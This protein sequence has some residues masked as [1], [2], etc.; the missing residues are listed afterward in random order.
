[1]VVLLNHINHLKENSNRYTI[2]A[3]WFH[4][5]W[6]H[7]VN[8]WHVVS[9]SVDVLL[10][11][12]MSPKWGG[13]SMERCGWNLRTDIHRMDGWWRNIRSILDARVPGTM[14]NISVCILMNETRIKPL[15]LIHIRFLCS[16]KLIVS[17][18]WYVIK[19]WAD[20]PYSYN[21]QI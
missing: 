4:L 13:S 14:L 21:S 5:S 6:S 9:V 2:N 15:L 12:Q 16:L 17:I 8:D 20:P 10:L 1:M 18:D 19:S 3:N 11:L 7:G